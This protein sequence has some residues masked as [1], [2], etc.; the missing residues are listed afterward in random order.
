MNLNKLINANECQ[1]WIW[2]TLIYF[3]YI[4]RRLE[5]PGLHLWSWKVTKALAGYIHLDGSLKLWLGT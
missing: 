5:K 3:I 4:Y 2:E 1:N